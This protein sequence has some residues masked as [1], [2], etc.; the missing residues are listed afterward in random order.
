[1]INEEI[2]VKLSELEQ[3]CKSNTRR[4]ECLEENTKAINRLAISVEVLAT[5][6]K[7]MSKQVCIIDSKVSAIEQIPAKRWETIVEKA[8]ICL[9]S[10]VAAFLL[11]RIGV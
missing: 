10:A 4:I 8:I 2:T 1:M 3:C 6:Q 11:A 5:E 9:V 7:N